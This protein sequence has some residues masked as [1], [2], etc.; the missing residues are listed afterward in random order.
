MIGGVQQS[1][2][3]AAGLGCCAASH[4]P[5]HVRRTAQMGR[6]DLTRGL[7][8]SLRPRRQSAD[9]EARRSRLPRSG[10]HSATARKRHLCAPTGVRLRSPAALAATTHCSAT[11]EALDR[12]TFDMSILRAALDPAEAGHQDAVRLLRLAAKGVLEVGV[13]PQGARA[14]FRGDMTTPQAQRV[15]GLPVRRRRRERGCRRRSVP[16]CRVGGRRGRG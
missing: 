8:D 4:A 12:P 10:S 2:G 1:R 13:P 11:V 3:N 15:L 14:D 9:P 6:I 5:G 7:S 16:G